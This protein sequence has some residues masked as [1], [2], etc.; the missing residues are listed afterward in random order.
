M[1]TTSLRGNGKCEIHIRRQNERKTK[2]LNNWNNWIENSWVDSKKETNKIKAEEKVDSLVEKAKTISQYRDKLRNK[3]QVQR[4]DKINKLAEAE[5]IKQ[6]IHEKNLLEVKEKIEKKK[7]KLK[8][9]EEEFQIKIR[10]IQ[11]QQQYFK[12]G[13]SA[14]EEKAFKQIEEGL[15]RKINVRQNNDLINQQVRESLKVS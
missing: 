2:W 4:K 8:K 3:K 13:K 5:R 7:K 14:V 10:E 9:E 12:L 1:Q 15:E 6:E 11:L